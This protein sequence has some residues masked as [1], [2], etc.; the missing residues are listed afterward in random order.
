MEIVIGGMILAP[1]LV[2]ILS[3]SLSLIALNSRGLLRSVWVLVRSIL[4]VIATAAVL[5]YVI[6]HLYD[7]VP[8]VSLRVQ[9]DF[10]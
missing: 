6:E 1:L 3:F 8:A 2:P 10:A 4:L 9:P 7:F 5:T